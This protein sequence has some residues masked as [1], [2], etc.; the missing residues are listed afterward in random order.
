MGISEEST[1]SSSKWNVEML[2]FV[3]GGKPEYLEYSWSRDK[4][5]QQ[6]QP[7][8][9]AETGD[10]TRA[11]LVGG[12]CSYYCTTPAPTKLQNNI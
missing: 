12:K 8:Y 5:Q 11:T 10:R 4:N 1:V 9:D 2:V 7:T 3:E 6:T